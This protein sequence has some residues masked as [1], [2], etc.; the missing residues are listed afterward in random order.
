MTLN[1]NEK[2]VGHFKIEQ[3]I[4]YKTSDCDDKLGNVYRV[5]SLTIHESIV[6]ECFVILRA[7]KR[8]DSC[9]LLSEISL[10]NP[11]T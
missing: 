10:E 4:F 3:K 5:L 11:P 1:S 6:P 7:V 2:L 9:L 8:L